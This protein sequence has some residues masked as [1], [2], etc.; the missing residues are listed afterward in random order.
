VRGPDRQGENLRKPPT[1]HGH[2]LIVR[3]AN[4]L[5]FGRQRIE[6]RLASIGHR[7]GDGA[8][9]G[10]T[11]AV[12]AQI[13]DARNVIPKAMFHM[14]WHAVKAFAGNNRE[15]TNWSAMDD[16]AKAEEAAKVSRELS[17]QMAEILQ[18][19]P[20]A[21]HLAVIADMFARLMACLSETDA[22][23]YFIAF[24]ALTAAGTVEYEA[25]CPSRI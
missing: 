18:E 13:V 19:H 8:H 23:K 15:P 12:A 16:K 10:A 21:V 1:W 25:Q 9:R 24:L 22:Q 7:L 6:L 11:L 4:F 3:D 14:K 2:Q 17:V 20:P 5:L